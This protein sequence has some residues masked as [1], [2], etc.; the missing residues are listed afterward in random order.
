MEPHEADSGET[1]RTDVA[2]GTAQRSA[3]GRGQDFVGRVQGCSAWNHDGYEMNV[4]A[5]GAKP[6]VEAA[7]SQWPWNVTKSL[8]FHDRWW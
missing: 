2:G 8:A 1:W 6:W 3:L 4:L 5:G 7:A